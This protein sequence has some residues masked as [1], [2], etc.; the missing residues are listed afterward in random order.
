MID[1]HTFRAVR[2]RAEEKYAARRTRLPSLVSLGATRTEALTQV[3]NRVEA[4]VA[5][6]M[7]KPVGKPAPAPLLERAK[8]S[9]LQIPASASLYA[10]LVS[11]AKGQGMRLHDW[12]QLKL[13]LESNHDIAQ[14]RVET[15]PRVPTWRTRC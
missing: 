3:V 7:G 8:D 10:Q 2:S 9:V 1:H 14:V 6:L 5:S 13:S 15:A 11:E 4:A 12:A